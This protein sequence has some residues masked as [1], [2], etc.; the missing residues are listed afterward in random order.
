[1]QLGK[2]QVLGI[3]QLCR[4]PNVGADYV[5]DDK[6]RGYRRGVEFLV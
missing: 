1:M 4:A 3:L 2:G 6:G 5:Q